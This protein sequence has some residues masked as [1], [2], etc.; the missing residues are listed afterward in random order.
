MNGFRVENPQ[1]LWI[2][3]PLLLLPAVWFWQRR[4]FM[5]K[6]RALASPALLQ[7]LFPHQ[8]SA[9][10]WIKKWLPWVAGLACLLALSGPQY[11]TRSPLGSRSG[12]D[13]IVALDASKSMLATDVQPNRLEKAKAFILRYLEER[14]GDRVG[15]VVFCRTSLPTN[16]ADRRPCRYPHVCTN[17]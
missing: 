2:C 4:S 9:R 1:W 7:V 16:A 15:L 12:V 14:P 11:A 3:L 13:V 5:R 17:G 6:Q 10:W 8:S